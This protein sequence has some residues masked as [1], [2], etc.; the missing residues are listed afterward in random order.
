MRKSQTT[1]INIFFTF[2]FLYRKIYILAN[3]FGKTQ[4][5]LLHLYYSA[6]R[7]QVIGNAISNKTPAPK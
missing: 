4:F 3:I 2:S 1:T 7:W 6:Y 5:T